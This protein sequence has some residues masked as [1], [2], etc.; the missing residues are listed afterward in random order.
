MD[1]I[2]LEKMKLWDKRLEGGLDGGDVADVLGDWATD[3]DRV[4]QSFGDLVKTSLKSLQLVNDQNRALLAFGEK[5][6]FL[7]GVIDK[8][9]G[10]SLGAEEY[11]KEIDYYN[12]IGKV[13]VERVGQI[14]ELEERDKFLSALE[15][16]GV[17]NW[18]GYSHA[19][20][21][22]EENK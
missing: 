22:L 9:S 14:K 16:A 4:E 21:I 20:E 17:D 11:L 2:T 8:L 18:E 1:R 15:A 19:H 3:V 13:I 10:F 6:N 5:I 12:E 7:E